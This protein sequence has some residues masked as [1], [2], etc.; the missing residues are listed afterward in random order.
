MKTLFNFDNVPDIYLKIYSA[1]I[2]TLTDRTVFTPRKHH[3]FIILLSG[4]LSFEILYN[5]AFS[6][7]HTCHNS[8]LISLENT[9]DYCLSA[10]SQQ[11]RLIYLELDF[12]AASYG[13]DPDKSNLPEFECRFVPFTAM[14]GQ[15]PLSY[16]TDRFPTIV[17]DILLIE[18]LIEQNACTSDILRKALEKIFLMFL[19]VHH[20]IIKNTM[21][22]LSAVAL[23]N[24]FKITSHP[25]SLS[26]S[27]ISI[28][29]D[30]PKVNHGAVLL[31]KNSSLHKYI[32]LPQKSD[33][34][35]Y[36]YIDKDSKM[37]G[38]YC[39][40]ILLDKENFKLWCFPQTN[41]ISLEEYKE[42][43]TITM[44]IKCSQPCQLYLLIY[45]IPSYL[46]FSYTLDISKTD[47]W[48][49]ISIPVISNSHSKTLPA[50]TTNAINYIQKHFAEKITVKDIAEHLHI[51]P[52][53]LSYI[54]KK[55]T[56]QSVNKYIN[57]YRITL[58]KQLLDNTND[59]I[60]SIA[61]KT[62][63]YDSQHFLKTFKKIS[64]MTPSDYRNQRSD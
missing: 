17:S 38:G 50:F 22:S 39:N 60:T 62:G 59:S 36:S 53:Y 1:Q 2:I 16:Y 47:T 43:A 40:F 35:K 29:S 51:H 8:Y 18:S 34:Y 20:S 49:D 30:N 15:N 23:T 33:C 27:D 41:T 25:F 56:G 37:P 6:S 46:S 32:E 58:A 11:C 42:K 54:F 10:I 26:L 5:E 24:I 57:F 12:F 9:Y 44:R 45:S 48:C 64:D 19:S 14:L 4:N 21:S 52:S 28:W 55:S 63:F 61:L 3:H 7:K 13:K 31:M